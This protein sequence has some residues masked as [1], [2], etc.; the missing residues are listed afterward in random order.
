M[1]NRKNPANSAFSA[2]LTEF[3]TKFFELPTA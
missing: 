1:H 3:G 2:L